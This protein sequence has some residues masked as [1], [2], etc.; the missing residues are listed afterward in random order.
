MLAQ[1]LTP[2][3]LLLA[4]AS[5]FDD[6][7]APATAPEAR[8]PMSFSD[9]QQGMR[10]V[11]SGKVNDNGFRNG[12]ILILA[13]IGLIALIIHLRQRKAVA[14]QPDNLAKLGR[15]LGRLV[16]FPLGAK[17]LLKWVALSTSTPFASLLLSE[18]LFNRRLAEW[19]AMPTF[20]AA[21]HW[22]RTRLERLRMELFDPPAAPVEM[23]QGEIEAPRAMQ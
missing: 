13:V 3:N 1:W 22:G 7:P 14:V 17:L 9:L 10:D 12:V 21:R 20:S 8:R 18:N 5:P 6:P 11:H 15:E 19:E 23:I 2:F 16:R 4:Q